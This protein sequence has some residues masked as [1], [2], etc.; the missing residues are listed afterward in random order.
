MATQQIDFGD[1]CVLASLLSDDVYFPP[2]P[3]SLDETGIS[4]VLI[5]A[6]ICK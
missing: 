1:Q 2:E 4:A 6:I 3:T 5:E